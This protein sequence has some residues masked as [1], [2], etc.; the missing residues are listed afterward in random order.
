MMGIGYSTQNTLL[1][2]A[3]ALVLTVLWPRNT[4]EGIAPFQLSKGGKNGKSRKPRRRG[5][6]ERPGNW[7]NILTTFFGQDANDDN[8]TGAGGVGLFKFPYTRHINDTFGTRTVYP[9]AM[10]TKD[11]RYYKY[12]I[13]QIQNGSKSVFAQVVDECA[14]GDCP[15]NAKEAASKGMKLVDIHKTMFSAIGVPGGD[16][17]MKMKARIVSSGGKR[18]AQMSSVLTSDGKRGWVE[19]HWK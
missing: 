17:K 6:S 4:I 2:L 14:D 3:L 8:G 13:L 7:F 5:Q 18:D 1:V 9:I 12:K 10:P 11:V 16:K 19:S 15:S